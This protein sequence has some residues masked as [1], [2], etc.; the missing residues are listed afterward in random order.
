MFS[1]ENSQRIL[2]L[3][4]AGYTLVLIKEDL[5]V[6]KAKGNMA[7]SPNAYDNSCWRSLATGQTLLG[8]N[9]LVSFYGNVMC[10]FI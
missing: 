5:K 6:F 9:I 4:Y 1:Q 8:N 7:S 2:S 10:L 3:S